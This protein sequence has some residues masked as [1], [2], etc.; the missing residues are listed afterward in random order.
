MLLS[1][2]IRTNRIKVRSKYVM[3]SRLLKKLYAPPN[4]V[5]CMTAFH[6]QLIWIR[7]KSKS[8]KTT[9]QTV[10]KLEAPQDMSEGFLAY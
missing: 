4:Q 6:E 9:Q 8:N 3:S 1:I 10:Q 5:K 7:T 2:T